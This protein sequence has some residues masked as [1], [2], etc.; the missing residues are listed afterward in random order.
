[1]S[2]TIYHTHT[3]S[4][5]HAHRL[6][7][8]SYP[9]LSLSLPQ[10]FFS[11]TNQSMQKWTDTCSNFD[12]STLLSSLTMRTY[13]RKRTCHLRLIWRG[14]TGEGREHLFMIGSQHSSKSRERDTD[15]FVVYYILFTALKS[16]SC[17]FLPSFLL[18]LSHLLPSLSY[19]HALFSSLTPIS[20][21]HQSILI[22]PL[23]P[24]PAPP[25]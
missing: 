15:K 1:M 18:L 9:S 2:F 5:P 22:F 4:L 3:I 6:S 11:S 24:C 10:M 25:Y 19:S 16:F 14:W 12:Q 7:Q 20:L 17:F 21:Q 8:S 13:T 23:L